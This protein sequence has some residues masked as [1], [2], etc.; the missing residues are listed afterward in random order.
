VG[1]GD[2]PWRNTES[3]V[4]LR[5]RLTPKSQTNAVD[6]LTETA[7]GPALKARV[8]A[9]PENGAANRALEL[10]VAEWLGV[11]KTRVRVVSGPK[12]RVKTVAIDGDVPDLPLRI[13]CLRKD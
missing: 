9:V 6:G 8:R 11:A 4:V 7:D 5:V 3:G 1:G 13:G 10:L 12:S 2:T